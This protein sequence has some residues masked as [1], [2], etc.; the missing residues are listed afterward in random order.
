MTSEPGFPPYTY[1]PGVTPH[2][3]RDPAGHSHGQPV[4]TIIVENNRIDAVPEFARGVALFG[5]GYYWEAHEEWEAVWH[6]VGRHGP[7]AD[8]LKA[9][10]KLAAAGVKVREGKP[11]GVQRHALRALELVTHVRAQSGASHFAGLPLAD[12]SRLAS[13]IAETTWTQPALDH[14]RPIAFWP[15]LPASGDRL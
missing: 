14:G 2:P 10:I 1:T 7:T 4:R 6:A 5:R 9:L 8:F 12:L 3:I 13:S 11:A 15:G